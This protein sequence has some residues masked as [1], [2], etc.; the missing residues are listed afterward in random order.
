M[1]CLIAAEDGSAQ[2][3]Q[4]EL[5]RSGL[6]EGW[7]F[8]TCT[9]AGDLE[10]WSR[11]AVD[12]LVLSRFLPGDNPNSLLAKVK[13]LFPATHIVLIAGEKSD[14][15]RLYI[16][17]AI[18][19]GL[20]NIVT[21]QLPG[22]RP[23]TIFEALTSSKEPELDGYYRIEESNN[24]GLHENISLPKDGLNLDEPNNPAD[25]AE[26]EFRDTLNNN[27][28]GTFKEVE[29]ERKVEELE[30]ELT[31]LKQIVAMLS[32]E[33]TGH[34]RQQQKLIHSP[35]NRGIIVC[36]TANKG[37][38]GKTTTAI[39]LAVALAQAGMEVALVDLDFAGPNIKS[40]FKLDPERGIEALAG[41]GRDLQL[42]T[43]HIL[44]PAPGINN[45]YILPGPADK[46]IPPAALFEKG[47]LAEV[48]NVLLGRFPVVIA[49][50]PP[51]FWACPWLPEIFQMTDLALAVVD[52]SKFSEDDTATYAPYLVKM[53][54][55]PENIRVVLNKF[56]P[57]LH[58]AKIVENAFCAGFKKDF[59]KNKLP[60]VIATIPNDWDTHI[61]K[62]YQGQTVGLE[63]ARSQWHR[64]AEEVA[65][66]AGHKY[67]KP[68]KQK[69]KKGI[70]GMFT[71]R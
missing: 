14:K 54:V 34:S 46:T 43:E 25:Y 66:L 59:P 30:S 19:N 39:T 7:R 23:Y 28:A 48:F 6:Y 1:I 21:G 68:D 42:L 18:D 8:E 10:S 56:S 69:N 57:R 9:S 45:L 47:A 24:A 4:Q 16:K 50:T 71:R 60:R 27:G 13:M 41:R 2:V 40:F 15:Q 12:V 35:G 65:A 31:R 53:G 26:L 17:N 51:N 70:L 33:K 20:Y 49:D 11:K 55:R 5:Q 38:V 62:G 36:T 67:K 37:G 61:K 52:Q 58:N 29:P 3:I 22:D 64:L 63:D 44:L 32:T